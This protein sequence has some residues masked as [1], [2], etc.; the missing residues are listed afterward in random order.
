M[1]NKVG[2]AGQSPP[3]EQ[4]AYA[5]WVTGFVKSLDVRLLR[6]TFEFCDFFNGDVSAVLFDVRNS[7]LEPNQIRTYESGL[8]IE[9]HDKKLAVLRQS[10]VSCF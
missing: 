1:F 10:Y 4:S 8:P 2:T 5:L 3:L 9:S 6:S 7:K